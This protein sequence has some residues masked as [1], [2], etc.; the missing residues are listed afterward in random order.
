MGKVGEG[1]AGWAHYP[2]NAVR[3]YDWQN[4]NYIWTD[5]ED[6]KPDGSGQK[7]YINSD[8][9]NGDSLRWF[10]Y[11]MQSYPGMNNTLYDGTKKLNNWWIF[12]GEYDQ[13]KAAGRSLEN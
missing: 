4:P 2:P 1:R 6:W 13:S 9:W 3:D 8:R 5:I 12:I 10:I 7:V 11:W